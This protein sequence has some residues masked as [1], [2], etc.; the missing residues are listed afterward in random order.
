MDLEQVARLGKDLKVAAITLSDAEAR[1]LVD[2]YYTMQAGRIAAANQVRSLTESD[3]P[4]EVLAWLSANSGL[5]ERNVLKALDA[6]SDA[7]RIGRWCR[8]IRGIGPVLSAGLMAHIDIEKAPSVSNIWSFAGLNPTVEWKKGKKRPWNAMLKTLC[9][10]IGESFVK[11]SNHDE[12]V[13]GHLIARRKALEI[14]RNERGD[15]ADLAAQ[16]LERFKIGKSTDAYKSYRAGRLPPAHIHARAKRWA[17]KLFLSHWHDVAFF[18]RYGQ[19]GPKPLILT[20]AYGHVDF[21]Q[22]P[23]F[24]FRAE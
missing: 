13:Y 21:L 5:L 7:H 6:Y 16:K 17:V 3:E 10:K 8:S 12:D 22:A 14:E 18:C 9:W 19:R 2:A 23:G 24:S 4:H 15:F 20:E 11:V 1:F